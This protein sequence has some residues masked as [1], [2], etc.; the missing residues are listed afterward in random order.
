MTGL[1]TRLRRL[2]RILELTHE[3][4]STTSLEPLL[5]KIVEAAAELTASEAAGIL[6]LDEHTG[7]LSFVAA[8]NLADRLADIP[9]P[10]EGSIAGRAFSSG[11]A[12]LVSHVQSDPRYY[13]GVEETTGYR[14]HSLLAVPLQSKDRRIGVLEAENKLGDAEFN[15]QDVETLTILAAHATVAI[16]NARLLRALQE[17]RNG[18]ERRVN[19][20]TAELSSANTA[21]RKQIAARAQADETLRRRNREL[22]VLNQASQV[23][24]SSLELDQVLVTVLEQVHH[25]LDVAACSI[26]LADPET[27]ELICQQTAGPQGEIMRG[28]RLAPGEGL[29]GQVTQSGESLIVA[30]MLAD[31]GYFAELD[32]VTELALRSVVSV[33]LQVKNAT[34]GVLQAMDQTVGRFSPSDLTLLEALAA[35]AAIAID[36]ARLVETLRQ[37]TEK[38][39]AQNEELDAFAHTV[40]HDLRNPLNLITGFAEVLENDFAT[41]SD[42]DLRSYLHI[43]ARNG[44]TM[45]KILHALLLLAGVRQMEVELVPLDM[46]SVVAEALQRV[47]HLIREHQ[48]TVRLPDSW[49]AVLGYGPWIED[50]WVNYLSNAIEHGGKPPC[51]EL[52]FDEAAKRPIEV[53]W[54]GGPPSG[55]MIYFWVR[56]NGPGISPEAQSRLFTPFTQ[57]DRT[58]GTGH[59]LGLSIARR[60]VEKMGGQV[61]VESLGIPGQ[62][63]VFYFT[64]PA[65]RV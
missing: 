6:L 58:R 8:T 42:K 47:D 30:D 64:L 29:A 55:P 57:L 48:A 13:R 12:L 35:S 59:G 10:I 32:Q 7:S 3:L 14:A 65:E 51:V 62:G 50:V 40:A 33:S 49:P 20:R 1:E 45:N 41:L 26:W 54:R 5:Y 36:N 19:E 53:Y 61:G 2:E 28:R 24:T 22:A 23:F 11:E 25:L 39:Q 18:L 4:T 38:L 56:D 17:A 27:G 31:E 34:I 46:A 15:Q 44:R 43:I 60:I 37:Q 63:S 52:G 16:E 9:V 21:L